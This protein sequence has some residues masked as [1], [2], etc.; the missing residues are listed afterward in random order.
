MVL[1]FTALREPH[2]LSNPNPGKGLEQSKSVEEPHHDAN[3]N[4][5]IQDRLDGT[6]HWN[7]AVDQPEDYP[8]DDQGEEYLN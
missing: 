1:D 8:D 5:R 7:E 3:D 4:H 2:S 6:C